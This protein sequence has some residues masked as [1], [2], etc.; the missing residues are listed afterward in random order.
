MELFDYVNEHSSE[1]D[2]VVSS[3]A[4]VASAASSERRRS[5][6]PTPSTSTHPVDPRA[7]GARRRRAAKLAQFFGVGHR[8]LFGDV[9]DSIEMGV[10]DE[11]NRGSLRPDEVQELMR[12]LRALKSRGAD[13]DRRFGR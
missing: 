8:E 11:A 9:L 13:M 6:P 5:L 2:P 10:R 4:S 7:F 12:R 3:G 1:E